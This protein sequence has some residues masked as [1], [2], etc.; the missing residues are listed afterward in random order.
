[1]NKTVQFSDSIELAK[2]LCELER[3]NVAYKIVN[4]IG[5]WNVTITGY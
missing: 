4:G 5:C 3:Q 2:Y 1:M